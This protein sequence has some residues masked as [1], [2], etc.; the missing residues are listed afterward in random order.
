MEQPP[1]ML[2]ASILHSRPYYLLKSSN[3]QSKSVTHTV[4]QAFLLHLP[5]P[6]R[7]VRCSRS[8]V[9]ERDQYHQALVSVTR[10]IQ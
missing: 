6:L 8:A 7:R 9:R 10:Y 1:R 3:S 4:V 2:E 5:G